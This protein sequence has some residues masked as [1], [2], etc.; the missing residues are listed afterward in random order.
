MLVIV[1][2]IITTAKITTGSFGASGVCGGVKGSV[3]LKLGEDVE[4][5]LIYMDIDAYERSCDLIKMKKMDYWRTNAICGVDL[6]ESDSLF[7][8]TKIEETDSI[9]GDVGIWL[10]WMLRAFIDLLLMMLLLLLMFEVYDSE[11]LDRSSLLENDLRDQEEL[12]VPEE[13]CELYDLQDLYYDECE[14]YEF[15]I[16]SD[17]ESLS[18][19]W[20]DCDA[21]IVRFFIIDAALQ[22]CMNAHDYGYV[23]VGHQTICSKQ[24]F[25]VVRIVTTDVYFQSLGGVENYA[26]LQGGV[27]KEDDIDIGVEPSDEYDYVSDGE[28]DQTCYCYYCCC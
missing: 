11:E 26:A 17:F 8:E 10:F 19:V 23:Y 3:K 4:Y 1:N 22:N 15:R 16:D 24:G 20:T 21:L 27:L 5:Q 13:Q 25:S 9:E 18:L 28:K 12:K 7:S 2:T 14:S 6:D